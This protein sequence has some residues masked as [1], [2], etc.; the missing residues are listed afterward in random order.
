MSLSVDTDTSLGPISFP[1]E[2]AW[3]EFLSDKWTFFNRLFEL[4]M[5]MPAG[6]GLEMVRR[7]T[8]IV[9]ARHEILRTGFRPTPHGVERYV[10]PSFEH[11]IRV[12]DEP[13]FTIN[14]D[15]GQTELSPGDLVIVWMTPGPDGRNLL[16]FDMNEMIC[17]AW[18]SS[19]LHG[20]LLALFED[21]DTTGPAPTAPAVLQYRE[22]ADEQRQTELPAKQAEYWQERLRDA[23]DP[24][25]IVPDGPGPSG[26]DAGERIIIFND[27]ASD[28]LHRLCREYRISP[29]VCVTSLVTMLMAARS[30]M[31]DLT[32]STISSIRTR[33]WTDVLGNF[34][35][36]LLLRTPLPPDPTFAE[37][38]T[39]TR[40]TVLGAMANKEIPFE[41][42]TTR[43]DGAPLMPP[44]R[45]HYLMNRDHNFDVLDRKTSGEVW[46]EYATFATWPIELGFGEDHRRRVTVWA[47][48]R[49]QL[50]TRAMVAELLDQCNEVLR[51]AGAD[52]Q[53]RCSAV[54]R[55]LGLD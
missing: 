26:D 51:F 29:F 10:L 52:P 31:R 32:L 6:A 46:D 55:H 34:S 16:L 17:D 19:R 22:F 15:P 7:L 38:I 3:Q 45:L 12:V 9:T 14:P 33:K 2:A 36:M 23:A 20:E 4:K 11:D 1:E 43:A 39:L 37:V 35:N 41:Q 8:D 44:I 48:Y 28:N 24:A 30:G 13:D 49:P 18:S 47:S 5:E 27:D 42:L 53:L 40:Q 21:P 25:Y 54:V 50:F